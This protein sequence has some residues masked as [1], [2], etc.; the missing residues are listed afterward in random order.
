MFVYT[1]ALLKTI[2]ADVA[3]SLGGAFKRQIRRQGRAFEHYFGP[4]GRDLQSSKYPG[5]ARGGGGILKFGVDRRIIVKQ[6]APQLTHT[7]N[8]S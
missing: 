3:C 5:F 2:G 8:S 6:L 7:S 4:K 1:Q